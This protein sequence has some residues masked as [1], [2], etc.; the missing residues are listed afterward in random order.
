M[1]GVEVTG[2]AR[3]PQVRLISDLDLPDAE[4]L[5]WRVMGR[6]PD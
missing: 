2:T 3:R 4:K 6:A 1:P 5:S